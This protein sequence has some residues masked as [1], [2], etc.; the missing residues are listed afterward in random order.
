MNEIPTVNHNLPNELSLAQWSEPLTSM[1]EVA[2]SNPR[3]THHTISL[4]KFFFFLHHCSLN[5]PLHICLQLA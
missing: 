3:L 4:F 1:Q 2:G 5:G